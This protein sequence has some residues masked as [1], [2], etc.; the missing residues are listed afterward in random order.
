MEGNYVDN[1]TRSVFMDFKQVK[2]Y[3]VKGE[4]CIL[5]VTGG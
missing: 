5:F 2:T 1:G 4:L 3:F